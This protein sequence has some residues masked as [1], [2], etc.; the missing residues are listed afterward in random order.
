L[1]PAGVPQPLLQRVVQSQR[2]E[3]EYIAPGRPMQNGYIE[4]FNG[5]L[6]DQCL[7]LRCARNLTD[8]L[9]RIGH[10]RESYNW[11]RPHSALC[12]L[13]PAQF[14]AQ[15][16]A[17]LTRTAAPGSLVLAVQSAAPPIQNRHFFGSPLRAS[18]RRKRKNV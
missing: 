12:Y 7:N 4:S 11:S 14:A 17:E 16:N 1:N 13:A 9:E 10:W 15:W 6:R 18:E 8:A 3:I 2:I 5:K